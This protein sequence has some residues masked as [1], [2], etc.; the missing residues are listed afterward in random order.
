MFNPH[1]TFF[2]CGSCRKPSCRN[3][4]PHTSLLKQNITYKSLHL[5]NSFQ[6]NVTSSHCSLVYVLSLLSACLHSTMV[7]RDDRSYL[8]G[9]TFRLHAITSGWI[10]N[11]YGNHSTLATRWN[12]LNVSS[13][14]PDYYKIFSHMDP[15]LALPRF[16]SSG[17]Y[18]WWMHSFIRMFLVAW[19]GKTTVFSYKKRAKNSS[20]IW[21]MIWWS[22]SFFLWFPTWEIRPKK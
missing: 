6:L 21:S 9:V 7:T 2:I 3:V 8:W 19:R 18:P 22:Y 4:V 17:G 1:L 14:S 13:A 16:V 5:K 20:Q 11:Q 12:G 15:C 10:S